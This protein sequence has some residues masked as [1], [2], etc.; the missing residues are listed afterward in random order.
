M[1]SCLLEASSVILLVMLP[2]RLPAAPPPP[3]HAVELSAHLCPLSKPAG[4][5]SSRG[6]L[7]RGCQGNVLANGCSAVIRKWGDP[8]LIF[9]FFLQFSKYKEMWAVQGSAVYWAFLEKCDVQRPQG[10]AFLPFDG[11]LKYEEKKKKKSRLG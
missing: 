5:I 2:R 3:G 9:F 7:A 8:F 10:V 11:V 4:E 6:W 1:S